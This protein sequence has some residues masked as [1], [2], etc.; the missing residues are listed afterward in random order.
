MIIAAR[1]GVY[2]PRAGP[3]V[4]GVGR[5]GARVRRFCHDPSQKIQER[6]TVRLIERA[7]VGRMSWALTSQA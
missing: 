7:E 3:G 1:L 6:L 4:R 2:Q 5:A